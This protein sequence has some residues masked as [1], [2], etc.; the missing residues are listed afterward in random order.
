MRHGWAVPTATDIAFALS[1]LLLLGPRMP[2]TLKVF[3]TAVA[4]IDDL[5][6]IAIIALFYT[7]DLSWPVLGLAAVGLGGLVLLNRR[8]VTRLA[9]YLLLGFVV[10]ACVLKSGVHPTLAGVAL[11]LTIPLRTERGPA[12]D[13]ASPLHR[14]ERRLLGWVAFLILPVFGFA[15][16]GVALTGLSWSALLD[17]VPLGVA[18]S[19]FLGKQLGITVSSWAG[20][21]HRVGGS[22]RRY[23][24]EADL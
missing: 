22:A 11:A 13:L 3:L 2:V 6:A 15:N 23:E 1:V 5:G 9:P 17:P 7:S 14:L 12:G 10:W 8:G 21:P 16:A 4:V 19:L 24:L 20:G 18:A